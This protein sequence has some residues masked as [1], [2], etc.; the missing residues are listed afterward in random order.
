MNSLINPICGFNLRKILQEK[1]FILIENIRQIERY[2]DWREDLLYNGRTIATCRSWKD[3]FQTTILHFYDPYILLLLA[4]LERYHFLDSYLFFLKQ[5]N[6]HI[7]TLWLECFDTTLETI[8]RTMLNID[9]IEVQLT[10][11][12]R[13]PCAFVE[14]NHLQQTRKEIEN[15]GDTKYL[16]ENRFVNNE[17][18]FNDY[19]HDQLLL[20]LHEHNIHLSIDFI[21]RLFN[22]NPTMNNKSRLKYFLINHN[23]LLQLIH[24]FQNGCELIGEKIIDE[25]CQKQIEPNEFYYTLIFIENCFY[26]LP[27]GETEIHDQWKFQCTGDPFIENSMMNLIELILSSKTIENIKSIEQLSTICSRI[28][29]NIFE[30]VNYKVDNLDC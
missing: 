24:I 9:R 17:D 19:F 16:I 28:Y 15:F 23:E 3:A 2:L 14:Y 27:P 22:S 7:K 12:L 13:L 8:D 6:E 29:D 30:L 20:F 21:F 25:I 11:D 26:Q 1:L 5:E 18:L 10:F 4:H